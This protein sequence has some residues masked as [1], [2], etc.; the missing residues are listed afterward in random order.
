MRR[1]AFTLV[2]LLVVIGII[3]VLIALLLPVFR[4]A[5]EEAR[6]VV[7]RNNERQIYL[8]MAAY[9]IDNRG[10]QPIPFYTNSPFYSFTMIEMLDNQLPGLYNYA[11]GHGTLWPYVSGGPVRRQQ[12]FLC[13][14]DGPDRTATWGAMGETPLPAVQ[15]NYSYNFTQQLQ[16]RKILGPGSTEAQDFA[17]NDRF[18][19]VKLSQIHHAD[20]KLLVLEGKYPVGTSM[21]IATL[22]SDTNPGRFFSFLSTRHRGRGNQCF[23]DGHVELFDDSV[24]NPPGKMLGKYAALLPWQAGSEQFQ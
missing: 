10:V 19:G 15:R 1:A 11:D 9:S 21:G 3:T 4:T 6:T 7:C 2:E 20:H 8:A 5:R 13:P 17:A 24:L 14:S 18:T 23:A 16:G 22:T 12:L